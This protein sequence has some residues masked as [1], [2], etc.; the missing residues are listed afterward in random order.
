MAKKIGNKTKILV[1][2]LLLFI[3]IS[4]YN[5]SRKEGYVVIAGGYPATRARTRA[6]VDARTYT[7]P[8]DALRGP[9]APARREIRRRI[10]WYN[11]VTWWY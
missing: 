5:R 9:F 8:G 7:G 1:A 4:I 3:G 6:R 10:L 2:L 11:P